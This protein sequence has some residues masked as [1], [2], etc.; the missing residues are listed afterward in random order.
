MSKG[1]IALYAL[2][3][4]GALLGGLTALGGWIYH[5]GVL[6]ERAACNFE[7]QG[8]INENIE[9]KQKQDNVGRASNR[10]YAQRLRS[11]NF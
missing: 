1:Y 11:G 7:K 6:S 3:A 2:L 9:I 4:A 8:A 5:K 10:A